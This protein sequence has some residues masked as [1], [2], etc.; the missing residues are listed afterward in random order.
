M[1]EQ[2]AAMAEIASASES[3]AGLLMRCSRV[4][5]NLNLNWIIIKFI[6]KAQC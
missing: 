6:M 1:E 2:T 3:L 5:L 4:L